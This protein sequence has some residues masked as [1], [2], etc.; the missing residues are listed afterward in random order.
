[1]LIPVI[2]LSMII[3]YADTT[4]RQQVKRSCFPCNMFPNLFVNNCEC[5]NVGRV[6]TCN[7]TVQSDAKI[8]RDLEV[9]GEIILNGQSFTGQ[10]YNTCITAF[11][12]FYSGD[13]EIIIEQNDQVPFIT[14][15]PSLNISF[16]NTEVTILQSGIY[17]IS[18]SGLGRGKDNDNALLEL[19][20]YALFDESRAAIFSPDMQL[21][22]GVST[23]QMINSSYMI[24]LRELDILYVKCKEGPMGLISLRMN[25]MRISG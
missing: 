21:I 23:Y 17:F 10:V 25:M 2:F 5:V 16:D 1:M 13:D 9:N 8:Y 11:G 7:L 15:E 6:E 18:I 3:A 24:D 19:N 14:D 22:N 20:R 12:S 4:Q